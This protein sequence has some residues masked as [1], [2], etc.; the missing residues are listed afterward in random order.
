M[1][2]GVGVTVGLNPEDFFQNTISSLQV[3]ASLP[4]A[5]IL[6]SKLDQNAQGLGGNQGVPGQATQQPV[7]QINPVADIGLPDGGVLQAS[8]QPVAQMNAG[9]SLQLAAFPSQPHVQTA[10]VPAQPLDLS[11]LEGPG[12]R[13]A[14][15]PAT[16]RTPQPTPVCPGQLLLCF[17]VGLAHLEQ[18][19]ISDAL[20]CFDESFLGLA[21]DQSGGSDIKAQ[22]T[23]CAQYKVTVM[24]LQKTKAILEC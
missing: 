4:P 8:Q 18:N 10:Q 17:K 22:A 3:A 16:Q 2:V 12:S 19:Q 9:V 5:G 15:K 21:K 24:L 11:S 14:E 20:S 23:I 13:N 6:I 7:A 1:G